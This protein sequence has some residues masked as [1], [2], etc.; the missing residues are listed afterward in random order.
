MSLEIPFG[1]RPTNRIA[2]VDERFGPHN[3]IQD[4]LEFLSDDNNTRERGLTIGILENGSV[5]EWVFKSGIEDHD[6]IPKDASMFRYMGTLE[7]YSELDLIETPEIG[8]FYI[9]EEAYSPYPANS[10]FVWNGMNWHILPGMIDISGK[11][12]KQD[13]VTTNTMLYAKLPGGGQTMIDITDIDGGSGGNVNVIESI[14]LNGLNI[15]PDGSKNINIPIF[16]TTRDGLVPK[17]VGSAT[18]KYLREDGQWHSPPKSEWSQ[19]DW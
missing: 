11:L 16:S 13:G 18:T 14:S 8:D 1:I 19:T 7:T 2:N 4:A 9:V 6:L 10:S 12:D 15:P 5:V 3:S 17:R